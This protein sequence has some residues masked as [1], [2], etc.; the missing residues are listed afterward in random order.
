MPNNAADLGGNLGVTHRLFA[1][2]D[3]KPLG[4]IPMFNIFVRRNKK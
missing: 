2:W 3:D 1:F 4:E